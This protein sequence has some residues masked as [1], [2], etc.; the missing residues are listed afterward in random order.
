MLALRRVGA[1]LIIAVI[2]LGLG[3][4]IAGAKKRNTWSATVTLQHPS[5]TK[6]R[7]K[8]KSRL[9]ACS[10]GRLVTVVY[11][12][13]SG[14][15]AV[16]SEQRTN[17]KGRYA[18]NLTQAAFPGIYRAKATKQRVQGRQTCRAARSPKFGV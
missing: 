7:G 18:V 15:S 2:A 3:G 17:R 5:A 4:V 8:V 9:A 6:F 16:L 14:S 12:S 10:R 13:P 11:T 1:V